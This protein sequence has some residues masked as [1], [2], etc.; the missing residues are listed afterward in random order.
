VRHGAGHTTWHRRQHGLDQTL[1][2][3]VPPDAPVKV[4]RLALRN[5]TDANRR[6][7]A[8]YFAEWQIGAVKSNPRPTV[9][10]EFEHGWTALLARNPWN[11]DFAE[12]VAFLVSNCPVHD[13]TTDRQDFLGREGDPAVPRALGRWGLGRN[14]R[15]GGDAC[16][17]YQVHVDLP[18]GGETEVV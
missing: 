14:V 16:A 4:A 9:D 17:A 18:P 15:P 11:P 13:F 8:T 5:L 3:F 7:T 12:R 2:V 1:K 10:P 6:L